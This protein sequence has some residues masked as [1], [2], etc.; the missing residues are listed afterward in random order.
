ML[1]QVQTLCCGEKEVT[2]KHNIN[3][4]LQC[5]YKNLFIG[6]SEFQKGDINAY[7]SQT[8]IPSLTKE[9]SQT[10]ESPITKSEL[11][12]TLKSMTNN[13]SPGN[14]GLAKGF[15]ETFWEETRIFISNSIMKSYQNGELSISQRRFI[16]K[17]LAKRLKKALP[18]VISKNQTAYVKG[19]FISEGSRLISDILEISD[20]LK[21]KGFLMTLDI[22]KA[23][24]S[25]DHLLL[26]SG[27]KPNKSKCKIAGL[28][29]LKGIKLAL[30]GME[31]IDL[32]FNSVKILAF[33]YSYDKNFKNQDYHNLLLS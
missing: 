4:E 13:K 14:D 2:D 23:F 31:C 18:S 30:S 6:K 5:F 22:E 9:Q 3:Q 27:L 10:C 29:A 11:L 26:S 24:D 21:V 28:G 16:S 8:N 7:F 32:M 20:N 15:F 1:N 12:N 17:V 33:Y 19:R 25:V